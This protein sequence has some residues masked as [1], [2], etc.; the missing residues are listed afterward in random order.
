[1]D[2]RQGKPDTLPNAV[3]TVNTV[4][5]S[6]GVDGLR[7][8]DVVGNVNVY[9]LDLLDIDILERDDAHVLDEA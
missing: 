7:L 3:N 8:I 5:R 1:M 4:L 2:D 9:L 6:D